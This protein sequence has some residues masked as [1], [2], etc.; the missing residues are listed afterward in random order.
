MLY[1]DRLNGIL[2]EDKFTMLSKR[3]ESEQQEIKTHIDALNSQLEDCRKEENR[4][5][6][7]S[8]LLRE[9]QNLQELD[10]VLLNKLID[11]IIVGEREIVDGK[12]LQN[13]EIHYKFVG[14]I[15]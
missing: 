10:K 11:K 13:I 14:S 8:D 3:L 7:F 12:R 15:E 5:Q 4:I 9:V 6:R 1:N 2:P